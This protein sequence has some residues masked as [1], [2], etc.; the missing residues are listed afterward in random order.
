MDEQSGDVQFRHHGTRQLS[1]QVS[2]VLRRPKSGR[3]ARSLSGFSSAASAACW[4]SR[5]I[6]SVCIGSRHAARVD[7]MLQTRG[8]AISCSSS[9][10]T[11]TSKS[12]AIAPS[13][14]W[15]SERGMPWF[16][17]VSRQIGA[18]SRQ[19]SSSEGGSRPTVRA[20]DQPPSNGSRPCSTRRRPAAAREAARCRHRRQERI[21]LFRLARGHHRRISAPRSGA[22]IALPCQLG[23]RQ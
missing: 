8:S 2:C 18:H 9:S 16:D 19:S 20:S 12:M 7:G 3:L 4:P 5:R 21:S 11:L 1:C 14:R 22:G 17:G 15:R 13:W 10:T 6:P 23:K